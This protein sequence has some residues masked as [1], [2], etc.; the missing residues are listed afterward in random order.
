MQAATELAR[1]WE[2]AGE[3]VAWTGEV[4][5]SGAVEPQD[6]KP[7]KPVEEAVEA[8]LADS[9][10]RGGSEGTMTK[11]ESWYKARTTKDGLEASKSSSLLSYCDKKGI[12]FLYEL[13]IEA[14]LDFRS[15]WKVGDLVRH[16]RQCSLIGFFWFCERLEWYDRNYA[17]K[18]TEGLGKINVKKTQT[19]YFMPDQ[20]KAILDATYLYSDKP[21]VDRHL[22]TPIT[23]GGKRIRAL[24]ELM[25]WTG[26]RIRD[27][28]TLERRKLTFENGRWRVIVYQRKTG[29][30][31][32]CPVPPHV[33]EMLNTIPASQKGNTN[34]HYFFWTGNGK[35]KT[36]VTN[37]QR[38]F[39]K[40]FKLTGL[41]ENGK[42]KRCHPH[43]FRDTFAVEALVSG[44]RVQQVSEI[45]GHSSI[46]TTEDHYL[47]WVR[48]RQGLLDV[49]AEESWKAQ[50]IGVEPKRGPGR[51]KVIQMEK[52][53]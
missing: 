31:V 13:T 1:L 38:S 5:Q 29:E 42:P 22:A 6:E 32:F 40:L 26:L 45:L 23:D 37:W 10:A 12:R 30:D 9:K 34:E 16:K 50:G 39:G 46:K 33:A 28:V 8:Y 51:P 47:G 2:K 48:A 4:V 14:M 27:A 20:Y 36:I 41:Q 44:M 11:K 7:P 53:A 21:S 18:I 24:M 43:M 17:T 35:E 19:G 25:R 52:M 15:T 3:P 49:A